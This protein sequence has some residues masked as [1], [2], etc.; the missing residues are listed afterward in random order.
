MKQKVAMKRG[1]P[2]EA[3]TLS[4]FRR[5]SADPVHPRLPKGATVGSMDV[6]A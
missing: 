5:Y 2:Q 6:M 4:L 1:T 3:L